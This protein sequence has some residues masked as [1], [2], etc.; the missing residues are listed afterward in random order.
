MHKEIEIALTRIRR[1]AELADEAFLAYLIDMV[2]IETRAR[3]GNHSLEA[4][5]A[6]WPEERRL[7]H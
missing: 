6:A 4:L 2:I 1:M 3:S 7:I 5:L